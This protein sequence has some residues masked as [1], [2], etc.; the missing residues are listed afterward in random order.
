MK[1]RIF[2]VM[3]L[4]AAI[5]FSSSSAFAQSWKVVKSPNG[6]RCKGLICLTQ[7]QGNVFLATTAI[8]P[9][10]AWA[11]GAEPNQSAALT[12]TLAEHWDGSRWSIVHT[13]AISEPLV[14]LNSVAAVDSNDVWAAGY[15]DNPSCICGKTVIEH[16]N[17]TAWTRVASPSPGVADY[18]TSIAVVS[19]TDIW[20]AGREW[21]SQSTFVPLLLHFDGTSWTP[22][23][24][25]KLH[26]GELFSL[27]AVTTDD[28]WAVGTI[29]SGG[30]GNA[31]ALHWDG[32]SWTS[33]SFP[34][35]SNGFVVL[36]SASGVASNDVWAVGSHDFTD[37][38]GNFTEHA[39]SFHWDGSQWNPVQEL[40][41]GSG[42][43]SFF[44]SVKAIAT[45]DVWEVG[46]I[47]DMLPPNGPQV[48]FHWDGKQWSDVPNPLQGTLNAVS[49]SASSDVWVVGM[50]FNSGGFPTGTYTIHL[51]P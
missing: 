5:A 7:G 44:T 21:I 39:V 33:A 30:S 48:T 10:V 3:M 18:L 27:F 13:P 28:I 20:A 17:G 49:A 38:F 41:G 23:L 36:S 4:T 1:L 45:G 12:A 11:V 6:S 37:T 2:F 22:F 14:Q 47:S 43:F 24:Q 26:F 8:S 16:W 34:A 35:N 25:T 51:V 29:G 40:G 31:L 42:T 9:T 19:A 32:V 46:Q 15:S 50:G